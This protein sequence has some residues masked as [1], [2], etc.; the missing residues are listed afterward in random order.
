MKAPQV[1]EL[2]LVDVLSAP[3]GMGNSWVFCFP[4]AGAHNYQRLQKPLAEMDVVCWHVCW[5]PTPEH[6]TCKPTWGRL[7]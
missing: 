6:N 5:W 2:S 7:C 1:L 3:C 4:L